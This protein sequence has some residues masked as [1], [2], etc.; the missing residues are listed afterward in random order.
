MCFS[1]RP[2]IFA[3]LRKFLP[4]WLEND[5]DMEDASECDMPEGMRALAHSLKNVHRREKK[6]MSPMQ[7]SVAYDMYAIAAALTKQM[8][9]SA[10]LA[11]KVHSVGKSHEVS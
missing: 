10:A 8:P 7:W 11:H 9:Y 4:Y 3:E 1:V 6:P 2:F 5:E